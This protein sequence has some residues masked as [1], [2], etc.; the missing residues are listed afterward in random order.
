MISLDFFKDKPIRRV[1]WLVGNDG[2]NITGAELG[3]GIQYSMDVN[4]EEDLMP[5]TAACGQIQ[6]TVK[7]GAQL[8]D[9]ITGQQFKWYTGA[10]TE[11]FDFDQVAIAYRP[12][13]LCGMFTTGPSPYEFFIYSQKQ[14][15]AVNPRTL[16]REVEADIQPELPV[17]AMYVSGAHNIWCLHDEAPWVTVYRWE[18]HGSDLLNKQATPEI[19]DPYKISQIQYLCRHNKSYYYSSNGVERSVFEFLLRRENARVAGAVAECNEFIDMGYFVVAEAPQ[20][21]NGIDLVVTAYDLMKKFDVYVDDFINS[22]AFPNNI[23]NFTGFLCNYVNSGWESLDF[24]NHDF[25]IMKGF[26]AK[27]VTG[28]QVLSWVAQIAGGFFAVNANGQIQF[29]DYAPVAYTLASASSGEPSNVYQLSAEDYVSPPINKVQI[30]SDENDI[31]VIVPPD[32]STKTNVYQITGNPLIYAESDDFLR[33]YAENLLSYLQTVSYSPCSLEINANP[34]LKPGDIISVKTGAGSIS[35][36][37]MAMNLG[38]HTTIEARGQLART[39]QSSETNIEIQ[40]LKGKTLEIMKTIDGVEVL[41]NNTKV[42]INDVTGV[43]CYNG[44]FRIIVDTPYGQEQVFNVSTEGNLSMNGEFISEDK[45]RGI[46]FKLNSSGLSI[47]VG[48]QTI[49]EFFVYDVGNDPKSFLSVGYQDSK[50]ISCEEFYVDTFLGYNGLEWEW[51]NTHNCFVLT[52]KNDT[53]SLPLNVPRKM[54][55]K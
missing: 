9:H 32:D 55:V 18:G 7:N 6:F 51:D 27:N 4:P 22:F 41:I 31:G 54:R 12:D 36:P 13:I 49:G 8:M 30:Q 25:P 10:V 28:R 46:I 37:I 52:S 5:G 42:T 38:T 14:L 21:S 45:S 11:T 20:K 40:R 47:Q 48:Q 39:E 3:G 17:K 43:T 23:G 1:E 35:V 2:I 15:F 24:R 50:S 34:L 19:A 29:R 26:A 44:G 33:P 53:R 16:Q